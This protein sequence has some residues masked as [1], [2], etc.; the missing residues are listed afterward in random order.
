[1]E[2]NFDNIDETS[3]KKVF[4]QDI[5]Y[6]KDVNNMVTFID[7]HDRNRF[8][9]EAG[10]DVKKMQN[11]LTFIYSCRGV[12]TVFQEQSKIEEM[13]MDRL[14]MGLLIHG[15]DGVCRQRIM[16]EK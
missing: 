15:I 5:L 9:T 14:L 1:M 8:L 6:G 4:D 13:Q 2:K 11:A 3:L 7:N 12:P 16:M 10:G